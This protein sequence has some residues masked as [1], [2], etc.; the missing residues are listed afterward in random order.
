MLLHYLFVYAVRITE[1]QSYKQYL[2]DYFKGELLDLFHARVYFPSLANL[3]LLTKNINIFD[4]T[5]S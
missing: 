3:G 2:F 1:T 5:L 4:I